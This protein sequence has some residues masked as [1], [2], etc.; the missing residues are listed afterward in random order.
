VLATQLPAFPHQPAPSPA[1]A[2][3]LI[4]RDAA[5]AT[6]QALLA[7]PDVRLVTITGPAGVGKTRL[8]QHLAADLHAA[9]Q[10]VA[11]VSL[12]AVRDPATIVPLLTQTLLPNTSVPLAATEIGRM[13]AAQ[14]LLLVL[15]NCEHLPS[16]SRLVSQLLASAP[17]LTI[18]ATSRSVLR[19]LGEHE[20]LLA[21]LAVP[22]LDQ[23]APLASLAQV[24]AVA[25]L[26]ARLQAVRPDFQLTPANAATIAA[27]CVRLDG[28]PLALELAAARAKLLPLPDL[29]ARLDQRLSFLAIPC[30]EH[31]PHQ[32]TLRQ[33]L[34]WSY[35]LL[36]APAR[37]MLMRL[38]VFAGSWNLA[39]AEA[40]CAEP[41]D[42]LLDDLMVL[43]DHSL[44]QTLRCG[45][46]TRYRLLENVH[47]Y[48]HER[49]LVAAER[50]ALQSR[51][52]MYYMTLAEQAGT[53]LA[54][55]PH[56]DWL[57]RVHYEYAN[58][59]AA[60]RWALQHAP[61][62]ARVAAPLVFQRQLRAIPVL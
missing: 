24:P 49:L 60:L 2:D 18:L 37:R 23:V 11:F 50:S 44:L 6:A 43:C 26:L 7:D 32:Q 51:H 62:R 40:I 20:L 29:L 4:G 5:L 31:L 28:L 38:A 56:A 45:D 55:A 8:A 58:L 36:P 52:A 25:L 16:L 19:V 3:P 39:A 42:S 12:A 15:D 9:D 35:R 10:Q 13:L 48:A 1:Y 22:D 61:E 17:H 59:E 54:D 57:Q 41:D 53:A 46:E 34:D 47:V 27:I 30:P 33:T 21:P 14:P